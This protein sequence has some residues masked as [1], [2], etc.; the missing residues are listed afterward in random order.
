MPYASVSLTADLTVDDYR[1]VDRILDHRSPDGMIFEAAGDS[2]SGL[3]VISIWRTKE[4]HDTYLA[5]RL[6]PAFRAA[7]LR[8]GP[9]NVTEITIS[10]IVGVGVE[11]RIAEPTPTPST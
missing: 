2:D 11:P 7:G 1:A 10:E 6:L 8:P 4:E 3:H 5:T 9:M